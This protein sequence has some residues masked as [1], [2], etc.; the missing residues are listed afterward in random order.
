ML[1]STTRQGTDY[2]AQDLEGVGD[3]GDSESKGP[4]HRAVGNDQQSKGAPRSRSSSRESS[5]SG[6]LGSPR[7]SPAPGGGIKRDELIKREDMFVVD[8]QSARELA[9]FKL[10]NGLKELALIAPT[11]REAVVAVAG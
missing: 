5:K 9:R 4:E 10:S 8:M 6:S 11:T 1:R 3:T 2:G 7:G